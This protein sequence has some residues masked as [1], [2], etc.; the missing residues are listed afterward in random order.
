[1]VV[2]WG[3]D[4]W[5]KGGIFSPKSERGGGISNACNVISQKE[6]FS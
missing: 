6:Q 2:L 4:H 3:V 5:L 1:M